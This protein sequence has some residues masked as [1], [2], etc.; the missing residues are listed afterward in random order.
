MIA[1]SGVS[2]HNRAPKSAVRRWLA[3]FSLITAQR[4]HRTR[5]VCDEI[6]FLIAHTA[7]RETYRFAPLQ[8]TTLC[9]QM[10]LPN[11]LQKVDLQLQ[12]RERLSLFELARPR[13]AHRA[14]GEIAEAAAVQCSHRIRMT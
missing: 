3:P 6:A 1:A 12:R 5:C 2:L 14:V 13:H 9:A 4:H 8:D 7:F 10:S 11:G